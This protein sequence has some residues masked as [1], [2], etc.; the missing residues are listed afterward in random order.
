[1]RDF[2]FAKFN[3]KLRNNGERIGRD[4]LEREA[5]DVV[6][7]GENEFTVPLVIYIQ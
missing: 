4:S 1:M 3:S 5:D 7:G 2:L 6:A